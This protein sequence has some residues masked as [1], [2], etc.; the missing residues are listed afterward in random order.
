MDNKLFQNLTNQELFD[1]CGGVDGESIM[2]GVIAGVGTAAALSGGA[3]ILI[4]T[5]CFA[6]G[7]Y[8]AKSFR[9]K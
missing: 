8:I 6:T 2:N 3:P 9:K 7:F 5:G 1:T 4:I